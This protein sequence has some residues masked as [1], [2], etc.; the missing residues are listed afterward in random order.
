MPPLKNNANSHM[1]MKG[2]KDWI[3]SLKF[4]LVIRLY[5]MLH[6]SYLFLQA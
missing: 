5:H 4:M 1:K 6:S 2:I 3:K